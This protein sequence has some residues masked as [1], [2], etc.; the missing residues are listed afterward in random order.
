MCAMMGR[1]GTNLK[2][3]SQGMMLGG[4]AAIGIG[5][6][7]AGGAALVRSLP[8]LI[9]AAKAFLSSPAGQELLQNGA[10]ALAPPG[11]N[12]RILN[13]ASGAKPLA[14]ALNI[15]I[16]KQAGVN[17]VADALKLP[18][19]TEAVKESI[20]GTKVP[21]VLL[22]QKGLAEELF[23]VLAKG[24]KLQLQSAVKINVAL[25]EAFEKAG[26][27]DVSISGNVITATK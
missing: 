25:K 20:V 9:A 24:G 4:A 8:G 27:K 17:V 18:L 15:D 13:I 19:A 10:E 7:E 26:F 5:L 16:A 14:G 21:S 11:G 2:V 1:P 6:W 3:A 23:R 12:I 22:G